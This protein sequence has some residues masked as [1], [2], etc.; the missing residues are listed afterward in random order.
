MHNKSLS[1]NHVTRIESA[2]HSVRKYL[3]IIAI[4]ISLV[5]VSIFFTFQFN[6]S[7][8]LQ[9][10]LYNQAKAF[11]SE[12]VIVRKWV[13]KHDGVYVPLDKTTGIN[14]YLENI[15]GINKKI[16]CNNRDYILK[17]PSL[18]TKELSEST[19]RTGQVQYKMT[20]LK[21]LNPENVPDKF[22]ASALEQFQKG[23]KEVSIFEHRN[24]K[25]QFRYMAPLV[26]DE[27]CL[28]CHAQQGYIVGDIRGGISV[29]LQADDFVLKIRQAKTFMVLG[30]IGVVVLV[31]TSIWYISRFFIRDLQQAQEALTRMASTDFLTGLSNR[32]TGNQILAKEL[33]RMSR[34]KTSLCIALIDLDH[35]KNVNDTY[36]HNVGDE[37][38]KF[39]SSTLLK[40]IRKYDTACRYGGEE[41]LVIMPQTSR[42]EAIKI[43]NRILNCL[44][45][46]PA[47]TSK[48]NVYIS[49]S[50][51]VVN[52]QN[53]ETVD[54]C[55]DRADKLLYR[56]KEDGRSR[57]YGEN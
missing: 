56:A 6:V 51:G 5:I 50:S 29:T 41:F 17:N 11:F 12:I 24:D 36:G 47:I 34:K 26:V 18:I 9:S 14:P 4:I 55:I 21:P 39:F 31:I 19:C 32:M 16:T 30:G 38:L 15:K 33:D 45:S 28:T 40:S 25:E 54:A 48:G 37:I 22:E 8:A 3:G 20:S 49:I 7:N 35:F 57:V 46:A 10:H 53:D 23:A 2:K 43:I 1:I 52:V 44:A 13:A 42:E 27:T